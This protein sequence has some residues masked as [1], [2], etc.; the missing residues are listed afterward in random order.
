MKI[1]D[2]GAL[3]ANRKHDGVGETV[4]D[5]KSDVRPDFSKRVGL[6]PVV[7]ATPLP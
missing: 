6:H 1:K 2:G 7:A 3:Y 5:D 4:Q